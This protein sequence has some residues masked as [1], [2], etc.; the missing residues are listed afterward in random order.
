MTVGM[1]LMLASCESQTTAYAPQSAATKGMSVVDA[2]KVVRRTLLAQ[3]NCNGSPW[4]AVLRVAGVHITYTK[5]VEYHSSGNA[6]VFSLKDLSPSLLLFS[7]SLMG[8]VPANTPDYTRIIA[9]AP[10]SLCDIIGDQTSNP[11]LQ[12]VTDALLVLKQA[13]S[14]PAR[15][16][17]EARFAEA[18]STYK[19]KG[20]QLHLPE[21]ARRFEVQAEAATNDK[22]FDD[23][24]DYYEQAIEVAPWWP[25]DHLNHAL[26]LAEVGLFADAI[27]EMKRYLML[28]PHAPNAGEAQDKIYDWE[29]K[30][31]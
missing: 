7:P 18:V 23:A 21:E 2:R 13:A 29:R 19:K 5:L 24:A 10:Y 12:H 20:A 26:M 6:G 9:I 1:A 25:A 22:E 3:S 16:D 31:K 27:T 28:V 15:A 30:T 17:D 8:N 11:A 14:D 4:G